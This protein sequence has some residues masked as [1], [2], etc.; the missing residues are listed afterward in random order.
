MK[1]VDAAQISK[2]GNAKQKKIEESVAN[3]DAAFAS[4]VKETIASANFIP[5]DGASEISM[6]DK[7]LY[8]I[9]NKMA[10]SGLTKYKLLI[11]AAFVMWVVFTVLWKV[12]SEFSFGEPAEGRARLLAKQPGEAADD[13][14]AGGGDETPW[15][16][17]GD[18]QWVTSA[19]LV[20][21]I[22]AVGGADDS[23]DFYTS[24]HFAL[25]FLLAVFS[26]LGVFAA[27][28]GFVND[29]VRSKDTNE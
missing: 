5:D 2:W 20:F 12:A 3:V 28:I 29:T 24:P 26:G 9:E 1:V 27:L 15:L 7:V 22:L 11:A 18:R 6:M 17:E 21:Q 23:I 8:R 19:Y 25:V 16:F 13:G 14:G 10:A 4:M